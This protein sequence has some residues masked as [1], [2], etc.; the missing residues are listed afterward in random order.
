MRSLTSGESI[1]LIS[2]YSFADIAGYISSASLDL[3]LETCLY[4]S[5]T[6]IV[7][8][9]LAAGDG[10]KFFLHRMYSSTIINSI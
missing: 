2:K 3:N 10:L 4:V 6:I 9:R 5:V 7:V 8:C 1:Q